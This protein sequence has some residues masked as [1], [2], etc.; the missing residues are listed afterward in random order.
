MAGL[1][2]AAHDAGALCF[3]DAVHFA[4]HELVDVRAIGCDFLACSP[5]KFYGPHV[6]VVYGRAEAT[7]A[8][9]LPRVFGRGHHGGGR[10][11]RFPHDAQPVRVAVAARFEVQA[12]PTIMLFWKGRTLMRLQGAQGYEALRR[13]VEASLPPPP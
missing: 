7:A 1:T 2:R 10:A 9:D 5:Y 13:Q 12:V 11:V 6:G 4:S 8:L 3:V